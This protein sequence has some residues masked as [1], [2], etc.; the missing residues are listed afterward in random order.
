MENLWKT[1]LSCIS[2]GISDFLNIFL[3]NLKSVMN[4]KSKNLIYREGI[5]NENIKNI[6]KKLKM[7]MVN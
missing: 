2:R 5:R 1:K 4:L 7:V 3:L 6:V